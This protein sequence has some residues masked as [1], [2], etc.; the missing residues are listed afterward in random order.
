MVVKVLD[1][2]KGSSC[3]AFKLK[4]EK[5]GT[6]E[7]DCQHICVF[8]LEYQRSW[9]VFALPSQLIEDKEAEQTLNSKDEEALHEV[10]GC[11]ILTKIVDLQEA[12][13][14][15]AIEIF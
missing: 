10:R 9:I 7:S 8:C 3:F 13:V 6:H 15:H 5:Y 1:H 4:V 2:C 14:S 11:L 12:A